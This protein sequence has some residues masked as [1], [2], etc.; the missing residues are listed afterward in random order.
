MSPFKSF[1]KYFIISK[2]TWLFSEMFKVS[3]KSVT[4]FMNTNHIARTNM[5][6]LKRYWHGLKSLMWRRN[7]TEKRDNST[8]KICISTYRSICFLKILKLTFFR[9]KA[10][11]VQMLYN[12]TNMSVNLCREMSWLYYRFNFRNIRFCC[13]LTFFFVY[14][15]L[16]EGLIFIQHDSNNINSWNDNKERNALDHVV[17]DE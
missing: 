13:F 14:N 1:A 8:A 9:E 2:I 11:T 3:K 4:Y 5:Y 6:F 17:V 10:T 7:F 12:A 15:C 16:K